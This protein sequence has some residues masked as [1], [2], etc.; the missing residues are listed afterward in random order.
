[1]RSIRRQLLLALLAAIT[2]TTLLG[3]LAT[4]GRAREEAHAMF[5]YQLR[6]LA[7]SFR[8]QARHVARER[9][10]PA[11]QDTEDFSVQIWRPDGTLIY[12]S[13]PRLDLPHR[14]PPGFATVDSG[15]GKWRVYGLWQGGQTIQVAQ[16]VSIRDRLA[17][18]A[19]LRTWHLSCCC[20]Q[21][22]AY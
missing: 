13:H 7:L 6:Q 17:L 5:D 18:A 11:D 8:D 12:F 3:A 22:L 1:M 16:P 19:A 10:L 14:A 2:L 4:Y 15:D 21:S 20:C 9:E